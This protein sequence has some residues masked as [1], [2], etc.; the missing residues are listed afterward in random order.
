MKFDT[1]I[2]QSVPRLEGAEKVSGT[3]TYIEDMALPGMLH[4]ALL[5]SPYAHARIV[6][7]DASKALQAPGVKAVLFGSD[8]PRRRFGPFVQDEVPLA[9]D[10]VR[11][12][13][14]PVAAVAA[15]TEEL[16]RQALKLID[17]DYEELEAVLTPADALRPGA[18]VLHAELA[19]YFKAFPA[20]FHGNVV[21]EQEISEG[22]VDSAWALCD[23]VIEGTYRTQAQC[24]VYMEPCGALA[25]VDTDGKIT[26]WSP[27][28]S[29]FRVQANVSDA[30]GIS[31]AKIR[32]VSPRIGGGFGGKME[33][34][35]QP[36][37]AA[38]A[39][40]TRRPVKII[41]TRG[42]DFQMIRSRHPSEVRIKTGAKRDG[43]LV[44]REVD[45]LLD[46]GAYADDSPGVL[47]LST[48]MSRGP[49]RIP[50]AR[51]RSRAV[52]TN[53]LRAGAFRGFGNPQITF[54]SESQF[55]ELAE[56]L[57][58]DP[59]ELRRKNAIR[60]GDTWFGG[61]VVKA[62]GFI[63]C[64]DK[65]AAASNW[66]ERR[67]SPGKNRALGIACV[68]H[69]SG[70]VSCSAIVRLLE[71]GSVTLNTAAVDIGQGS[72][73]VLAQICAGTL[74]IDVSQINVVGSDTDAAPYNWGTGG[75]RTTHM[76]GRAVLGATTSVK[77]QIFKHAAEMLQC[78]GADLELLPGGRVGV[79]GNANKSV[80]FLE[81]SKRTHWE[82]GGPIVGL[83]SVMYD[84]PPFDP[85]LATISGFP[86]LNMGGYLFG[87]QVADVEVDRETG[88]ITVH[89]IWAAHDVGKAINP[90]SVEGQI[91]GGVVQGLGYALLEEMVWDGPRLANPSLMD[92]KIPSSLDVPL[93]IHPFIVEHP[94]P[95]GPLGAKGVGEPGLVAVAP[96]IANA[97]CA[98]T[99]VRLR[100]LPMTGERFLKE[101]M[102]SSG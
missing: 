73:T 70:S 4:A 89:E 91:Q 33:A 101:S 77:K 1:V 47:G 5:P 97:V 25:Q 27:N 96:T 67:K 64:L 81:V 37:A 19:D 39:L 18:P 48:L 98:A 90:K 34:T 83:D 10:K 32:A 82:V 41:L 85:K 40:K 30:L 22:D 65:V 76:V 84:G 68:T 88:T 7:C 20:K 87:A 80:S 31:M 66:R 8:L 59:L 95:T 51:T 38:L 24:H 6:R 69:D 21:S 58:M 35:V 14:E 93:K 23:V 26:I 3:A 36:I 42:E 44:A 52:Y 74:G 102:R 94:E 79:E 16:A 62:C 54:A 63:E 61:Q 86:F 53:K 60:A 99:G 72:D 78:A 43:T 49:Y 75:S 9:Q 57:N 45:I 29:V 11:Y 2:G 100:E 28:Q 50:H 12:V 92:Y 71:D 17:I 56:K 55:D 15:E 46:G 13:G